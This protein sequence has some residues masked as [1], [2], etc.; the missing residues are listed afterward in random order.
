MLLIGDHDSG[1]LFGVATATDA[2]VIVRLRKAQV[3]EK[4]VRH[5]R[6]VV[7]AGVN[8]QRLAPFSALRAW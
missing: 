1:G 5:V 2:E 7:L 4:R 8:Q 3:R 6:V